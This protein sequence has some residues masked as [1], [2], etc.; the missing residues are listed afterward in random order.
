MVKEIRSYNTIVIHLIEFYGNIHD[1]NE[2][3]G[4]VSV[5]FGECRMINTK[6]ILKHIQLNDVNDEIDFQ[7]N[8]LKLIIQHKILHRKQFV[9]V[10]PAFNIY[11]YNLI[12]KLLKVRSVG[13]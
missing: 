5:V 9:K 8:P 4:N 13:G 11:D 7:I 2:F 3:Y 1:V 10:L 6:N 12:Y